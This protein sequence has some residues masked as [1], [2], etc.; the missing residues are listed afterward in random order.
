MG[1]H[2]A[3]GRCP[4]LVAGFE[5]SRR[6]TLGPLG[7][8]TNLPGRLSTAGFAPPPLTAAVAALCALAS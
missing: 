7:I 5:A 1:L 2:A 3:G 4:A 6:C 8:P